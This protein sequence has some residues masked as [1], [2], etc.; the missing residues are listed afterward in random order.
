M[1]EQ[2]KILAKRIHNQRVRLREMENFPCNKNR[3]WTRS[4]WVD[5]ATK[6]LN[7]NR[8]LREEFGV[9]GRFDQP[10]ATKNSEGD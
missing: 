6:A 7:E 1:T 4:M 2:E 5:L 8:K 9:G 3:I 10:N